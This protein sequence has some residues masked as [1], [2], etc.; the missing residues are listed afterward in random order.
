MKIGLLFT[1]AVSMATAFSIFTCV[2]DASVGDNRESPMK[3]HIELKPANRV[4]LTTVYDNYSHNPQLGTGWGFACVIEADEHVILFDTGASG[5]LLL[6]NMEKLKISPSR[7]EAVVLSHVH[8]DHTGGLLE[9]LEKNPRVTVWIPRSFPDAIREEIRHRGTEYVDVSGP[10][11]IF[12]SVFTTGELGTGIKEQALLLRTARGQVVL[13]GCA[14]PGIVEMVKAAKI[15][16]G[17]DIYLVIGGFHLGGASE[18]EVI[19]I[20]N[21]LKAL[22]VKKAAPCH[23]SGQRTRE[24]FEQHY[25]NEYIANGVG[26]VI[27]IE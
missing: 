25:G 6:A 11:T 20:I 3:E 18:S 23:C 8:G 4:T 22:G 17:E 1:L 10:D 16:T 21:S 5:G 7:V 24:L 19:S 15:Q 26:K 13:T 9:F 27:V 2:F 12:P 14:H